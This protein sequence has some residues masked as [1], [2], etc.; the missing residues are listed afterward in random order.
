MVLDPVALGGL[1]RATGPL[2]VDGRRY[3]QTSIEDEL[4]HGQY[5]RFPT[6]EDKPERREGLGRVAG[7]IFTS[8]DTGSW[9]L[10][11]LATGLAKAAGGRH[12]LMWASATP[13]QSAW[14]TLGVDGALRPDSLLLSV[15]NRGGNKLDRFLEVQAQLSLSAVGEETEVTVTVHLENQVPEGEPS[16]VAGPHPRSGVAEGVYVGILTL[17]LPGAARDARFEGVDQLAV[18]GTDGPSQVVGFQ[19][20]LPRRGQRTVVARFRLPASVRDMRVE[21]S[22]RVPATRWDG[23]AA[24][25]ADSSEKILVWRD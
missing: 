2:Q 13:E 18:R 8:L 3:D 22:A 24:P 20:E 9:S 1:L 7:A 15:L 23:G 5:L 16:Y 11:G 4:L 25:W 21:P 12:L 6:N 14:Q 17:N 19:F 10:P